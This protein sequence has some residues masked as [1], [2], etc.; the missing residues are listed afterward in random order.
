MKT[1][2]AT[3]LL[4]ALS[5]ILLPG[6]ARAG[7]TPGKPI[8]CVGSEPITVKGQLIK[9]AVGVDLKGSCTVTLIDSRIEAVDGIRAMGSGD[10][11]LK[12]T[13]VVASKTAVQ[14]MGSGSVRCEGGSL[15]GKQAAVR[16]AA[17]GG[18]SPVPW[19]VVGEVCR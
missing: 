3:V 10:V 2:T 1:L 19:K 15:A 9:A 12:N 11:I 16:I 14:S 4:L 13:V 18:A 6:L 7:Y 8:I 5:T 17:V